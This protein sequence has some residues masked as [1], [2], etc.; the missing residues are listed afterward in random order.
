VRNATL[1][2]GLRV[3][4]VRDPRAAEVQVTMQYRVG[5]IDDPQGQEGMAHL[6]EHLMFQQVLGAQSLFAKLED[7]ATT[8]NAETKAEVTTYS[9]RARPERLDEL[10]SIEAVRVGFRCTSISEAT[11]VRERE[12]VLQELRL[13]DADTEVMNAIYEGVYPEGHPY[14]RALADTVESVGKITRDQACIFADTHYTTTNAVL[15]VSGDITPARVDQGLNKF[16]AKVQKRE[17][18]AKLVK[19]PEPQ[20]G[21]RATV[22]APFDE[23]V[24]LFTWPMP[25]DPGERLKVQTV[26]SV[27]EAYVDHAIRG[28]TL[29]FETGDEQARTLCIA[30]I[31][32]GPQGDI[33]ETVTKQLAKLQEVRE[34]GKWAVEDRVLF[35]ILHS[36]AMYGVFAGY[37]AGSDRD[38][39][40]ARG[41]LVGRDPSLAL[42]GDA[43]A[44]RTLTL[45][46]ALRVLR[47]QLSARRMSVVTL[48]PRD[49]AK[50]GVEAKVTA[51][52][53]DIGQRRDPPDPAEAK[54]PATESVAMPALAVKQERTL[55]NGLRVV[56]LPVTSVPTVEIRLV[57]RAGTA[58]DPAKHRGTA[59]VAARGLGWPRGYYGDL[60]NFAAAGAERSVLVDYDTTAFV[61]RGLDMHVDFLLTG[62]ARWIRL[63]SYNGKLLR[64]LRGFAPGETADLDDAWNAALFGPA[65]PYTRAGLV[66]HID[67]KLTMDDVLDWHV[68][69]FT[70]G[71]AT[72]VIA[73]K[74]DAALADKWIDHLF[75]DWEGGPAQQGNQRATLQPLSLAIDDDLAQTH[76]HIALPASGSHATQLVLAQMLSD[77]GADIRHQLA[78]SYV[79]GATLDERRLSS[80]YILEGIVDAA[81]TQESLELVKT[82]IA[83]LRDDPDTAARAFVTA[84]KRTL[85]KLGGLTSSAHELAVRAHDD[86]RHGRSIMSDAR[87]AEEVQQLTIDQMASA[88]AE[89]DLARAAMYIH[90]PVVHVDP[91]FAA[92]GRTPRRIPKNK[93][94]AT[95]E[96]ED[97]AELDESFEVDDRPL[98]PGQRLLLGV[99]GGY[100]FMRART[101]SM[102]GYALG[103]DA[104]YRLNRETTV[105]LHVGF[106]QSSGSYH[107]RELD[108]PIDISATGLQLHGFIQATGLERLWGAALVGVGMVN[109][110]EKGE[111]SWHAAVSAGLQGGADL[112]VYDGHR[113][114]VY[115]RLDTDLFSATS[116][117]VFSIGVGYRR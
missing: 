8:F 79:F 6:V 102:T 93:V 101:R 106:A 105:G 90:G 38:E 26:A 53:H 86:I 12:V 114:G 77:I 94:S 52:V 14:R 9:S 64:V 25:N 100:G 78:A 89:L 66:R 58:D 33:V 7:A 28:T 81:R 92:L 91:A 99:N 3:V 43:S 20:L 46:D 82:R 70:P 65:H 61:A 98:P 107:E 62:L 112:L 29:R 83:A 87:T 39:M 10:L 21:R 30:V 56:L 104:G 85:A 24:L 35:S 4:L 5:A 57:F 55:R 45:D 19:I 84:R 51:P 44:L 1:P 40:L 68:Q 95:Q 80:K 60:L 76:V 22:T 34:K 69:H 17:S 74:F 27:L 13:K 16:L 42:A 115:G 108:P 117:T 97:D 96:S 67:P 2:N 15:V 18:F 116:Y 47:D 37:E 111:A 63:G 110:D 59:L 73:G 36:E 103:A 50:H 23:E 11:F 88:L 49:G 109:V 48:K 75:G 41:V 31:P 54:R 71:N 113:V 32:R 72:L